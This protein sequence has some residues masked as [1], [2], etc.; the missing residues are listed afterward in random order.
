MF[1]NCFEEC[2]FKTYYELIKS[3]L[4]CYV[5]KIISQEQKKNAIKDSYDTVHNALVHSKLQRKN[6][7]IPIIVYLNNPFQDY[8]TNA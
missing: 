3:K 2:I 4:K 6:A 5:L 1:S 7:I 8:S